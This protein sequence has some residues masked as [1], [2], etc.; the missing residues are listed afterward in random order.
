MV[1][2]QELE[3]G[4][5]ARDLHDNLGQELTALKL[6]LD[7]LK[8]ECAA[9]PELCERIEQTREIARRVENDLDFI[10][11]ELRPA[12]LDQ[13]GLPA[14]LENFAR[15][16]SKQHGVECDFHAGG[17]DGLRLQPEAETNLYR[18]AQEAL[19]NVSKHAGAGRAEVL[20]DRRDGHLVFI[21]GDDG[22]GFEPGEAADGERGMG[23]LS[24]RERAE[25]VGGTLEIESGPSA[26]TT[27]YVRVPIA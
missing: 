8:A 21:V 7:L 1:E 5:I 24:M 18:I 25:Q 20:L 22:K 14:T 2:A 9:R 13:L 10:S 12:A 27:V 3:R 26:G 11:W 19:N 6:N 16:W 15:E 17:A 4:R 23:L